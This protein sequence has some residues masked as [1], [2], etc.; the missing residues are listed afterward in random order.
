METWTCLSLT[1][2]WAS[3]IMMGKKTQETRG[4]NTKYRGRL[5]IHA[6]KG[7]PGYAQRVC[8][9]W[10]FNEYVNINK[11]SLPLG[12]IL[13]YV[14]LWKTETTEACLDEMKLSGSVQSYKEEYHF[15]DYGEGRY[16]WY[17]RD[18]VVFEVP[19]VAKGA[20]SLWKYEVKE[21]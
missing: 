18:P 4:W 10:P 7:F 17:L 14:E 19:I 9:T 3:L 5:Y 21:I 16:V 12:M 8:F 13:G 2:P 20:L 6:S 1:Q 11:K 15:G